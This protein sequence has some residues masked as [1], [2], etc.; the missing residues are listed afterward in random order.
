MR[1]LRF[2]G[3]LLLSKSLLA[4][5][6]PTPMPLG[7]GLPKFRL[8]TIPEGAIRTPEDYPTHL[9][10]VFVFMSTHCA[11][12]A[13]RNKV[14]NQLAFEFGKQ[15][16]LLIGVFSGQKETP[17]GIDLYRQAENLTFPALRDVSNQFADQ[18]G[19]RVT[20]EVFVFDQSRALRYRGSVDPLTDP[21]GSRDRNLRQ[22]LEALLRNVPVP[23]PETKAFGCVI[24][25]QLNNRLK[26]EH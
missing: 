5:E 4:Q 1:I 25:R 2:F 11:M 26:V 24:D 6:L 16:V 15:G 3:V 7:Q 17:I 20:P 18:L 19:A 21:K 10:L 12:S 9:F 14:F 13:A 8:V 23:E 22:S